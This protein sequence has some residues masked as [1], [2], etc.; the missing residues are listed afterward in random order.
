MLK[1]IIIL[2][3]LSIAI[4][5]SIS[6]AQQGVTF[7]MNAHAWV[8][9]LLTHLFSEGQAGNLARGLIALLAIPVLVGI[10]PALVYYMVKRS[11]FPWFM[12]IVW[13]VWLVQAGALMMAGG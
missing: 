1:Q 5:F 12:Q 13:V 10:V 6:Y 11:A 7:L 4:V 8:A 2:V 3:A 9:Q